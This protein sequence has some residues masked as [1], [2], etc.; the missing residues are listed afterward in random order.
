MFFFLYSL[1]TK[2]ILFFSSLFKLFGKFE[3]IL[4]L[5]AFMPKRPLRFI[6]CDITFHTHTTAKHSRKQPFLFNLLHIRKHFLELQFLY[7]HAQCLIVFQGEFVVA[8][9]ILARNT[10]PIAKLTRIFF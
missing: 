8:N 1:F 9:A 2:I 6:G 3:G 10:Y 7:L 5:E 4:L